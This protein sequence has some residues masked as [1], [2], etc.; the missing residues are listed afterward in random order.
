MKT[1][2]FILTLIMS[3][4]FSGAYQCQEQSISF[5]SQSTSA[6]QTIQP[7][8]GDCSCEDCDDDDEMSDALIEQLFSRLKLSDMITVLATIKK[9]LYG[10]T[11]YEP[12]FDT[13][14]L[15]KIL[16]L[17]SD[18][19]LSRNL[20]ARLSLECFV[21]PVILNNS[22]YRQLYD[23]MKNVVSLKGTDEE[24]VLFKHVLNPKSFLKIYRKDEIKQSL[25]Q[26]Y[27]NQSKKIDVIVKTAVNKFTVHDG[28]R[29]LFLMSA[30]IKA[31]KLLPDVQE[32][33]QS[34]ANH[35]IYVSL[36]AHALAVCTTHRK[37]EE[38]VILNFLAA[39]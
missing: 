18:E 33:V 25:M 22:L 4:A 13:E 8:C 34:V 30:S 39:Q 21:L 31:T 11:L 17:L 26:R 29:L 6:T 28:V 1:K 5:S 2:F 20:T 3:I 35:D 36:H 16:Q 14:S 12:Y 23:K 7:C 24:K 32:M 15:E 9:S 10:T 27:Q 19:S 37:H 38:K